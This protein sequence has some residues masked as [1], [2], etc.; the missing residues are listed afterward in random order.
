MSP[1]AYNFVTRDVIGSAH[2]EEALD[3]IT[4][5]SLAVD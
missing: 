3:N 1:Q 5:G 4:Y 2:R